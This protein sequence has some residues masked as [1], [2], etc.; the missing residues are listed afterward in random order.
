MTNLN[1]S[2]LLDVSLLG[3]VKVHVRGE[4]VDLPP[5][6]QLLLASLIELR[7]GALSAAQLTE[8]LSEEGRRK[9]DHPIGL[10]YSHMDKLR[11][12]LRVAH[13]DAGAL[14]PDNHKREGYRLLVGPEVAVDA[15]RFEDLVKLA[16]AATDKGEFVRI[17]EQALRQ[18]GEI[19]Q[20]LR[21]GEPLAGLNGLWAAGYRGSLQQSYQNTLIAWLEARTEMGHHVE[22]LP[23]LTQLSSEPV[24]NEIVAGLY[25]QSLSR[26][27]GAGDAIRAFEQIEDRLTDLGLVP[28]LELRRLNRQLKTQGATITLVDQS[29]ERSMTENESEQPAETIQPKIE[30]VDALATGEHGT[31]IRNQ[32]NVPGT[33]ARINYSEG[34]MEVTETQADEQ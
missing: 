34:S 32:W 3:R 2:P 23:A 14:I 20:G 28:A 27:G 10:F 13:P 17:A 9:A 29:K 31:A 11:T 22:L 24:P 33:H 5:K 12:K 30:K 19:P 4:P 15:Y 7:G 18:W 21:G 26:A 16:Q 25:M 8:R 1:K 6:S